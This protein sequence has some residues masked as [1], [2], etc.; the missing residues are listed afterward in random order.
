MKNFIYSKLLLLALLGALVIPGISASAQSS[1]TDLLGKER[2]Y[3]YEKVTIKTL[4]QLYWALDKLDIEKVADVDYFM[5]INECDIY[6]DYN[7]HEFEWREIRKSAKKYI[8]DNKKAFP[9]RFEFIQE[10]RLSE[11]DLKSQQFEVD[12]EYKIPRT[13]RFEVEAL[14]ATDATTCGHI[15]NIPDYPRGLIVEFSRPF[16]LSTLPIAPDV[17]EKYIDKKMIAF[18]A[19]PEHQQNEK[20]LSSTRDIYLVMKIKIF[21]YQGDARTREGMD[22]ANV[23]GVLEGFDVYADQDRKFLLHSEN[24]IRARKKSKM[25]EDL[26]RQYQ[27]SKKKQEGLEAKQESEAA[28]NA[29]KYQEEKAIKEVSEDGQTP[30][31]P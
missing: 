31:A 14:D 2:K 30:A 9:L 19:L 13:R 7:Q 3:R 4:S 23:L 15:G 21:S 5:M 24:Y 18:R 17:A 20:F 25:E 10:L 28:A 26:I 12:D 11:Y 16:E 22:L 29:A 6:K 1:S 27:E 8:E